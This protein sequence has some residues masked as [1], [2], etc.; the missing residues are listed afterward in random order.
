MIA[1]AIILATMTVAQIV[2]AQSD[3]STPGKD[4]LEK[5]CQ[6]GNAYAYGRLNGNPATRNPDSGIITVSADPPR[7]PSVYWY[8][9]RWKMMN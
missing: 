7:D 8:Q 5:N 1:L 2:V 9:R 4:Q 3:D 6:N